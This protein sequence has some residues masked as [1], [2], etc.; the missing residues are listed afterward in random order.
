VVLLNNSILKVPVGEAALEYRPNHKPVVVTAPGIKAV[1]ELKPVVKVVIL[2]NTKF[3]A[4]VEI[5][6]HI[7]GSVQLPDVDATNTAII[8]I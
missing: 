6:S 2:V 4:V 3:E 7:F 1:D 8:L 5:C